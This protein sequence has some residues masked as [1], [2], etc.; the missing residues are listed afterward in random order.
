MQQGTDAGLLPARAIAL[1]KR[2]VDPGHGLDAAIAGIEA[3][4]A[5]VESIFGTNI[6]LQATADNILG[7]R[8][9][10]QGM[11][12]GLTH[13]M[14]DGIEGS[15]QLD[16]SNFGDVTRWMDGVRII[17]DPEHPEGEI[18]LSGD[19]GAIWYDPDKKTGVGLHFAGEDATG[20]LA[21]Y[22]LAHPLIPVFDAIQIRV[23]K[24]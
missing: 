14:I 4:V 5:C 21:Q 2:W 15:H 11:A 12:S 20:P 9:M 7:Q 16:Y 24:I 17:A 8:V 1:L 6:M 13:G 18:S 3:G 23:V 19:S 10:K 22:A